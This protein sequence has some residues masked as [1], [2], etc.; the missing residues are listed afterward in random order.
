MIDWGSQFQNHLQRHHSIESINQLSV[1]I[2]IDIS[3]DSSIA[4]SN[5]PS[6]LKTQMNR[7]FL[8]RGEMLCSAAA[9][10]LLA[11]KINQLFFHSSDPIGSIKLTIGSDRSIVLSFADRCSATAVAAHKIKAWSVK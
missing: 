3:M 1:L 11:D 4:S 8:K 10:L 5:A 6:L 2:A 9:V 7:E